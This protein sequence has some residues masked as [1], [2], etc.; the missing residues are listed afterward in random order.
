MTYYYRGYL[1]PY[2]PSPDGVVK[3]MLKLAQVSSEDI[4]YDLGA[5][6]GRI[7][8]TAVKEFNAKKAIG[9]E[10]REDLAK[11]AKQKIAELGLEGRAEIINTDMFRVNLKDATVITL[12]LLTSVN[13]MLK[14]KFERELRPG[15]RIVSHEFQIPGWKPKKTI[16][17]ID[18]GIGHTIY[19]YVYGEHK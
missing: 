3:A 14:P 2:V 6:D 13:E 12:F 15:T 8:I 9:V 18:N 17:I 1:V 4:V 7:V 10:I 5:G 11:Q 19:L 16:K